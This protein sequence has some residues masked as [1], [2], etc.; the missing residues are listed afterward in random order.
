MIQ[1]LPPGRVGQGLLGCDLGVQL[2]TRGRTDRLG[3]AQEL[4]GLEHGSR[5]V[6]A[7]EEA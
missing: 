4:L 1:A 5:P 6:L 2:F 7:A 3:L